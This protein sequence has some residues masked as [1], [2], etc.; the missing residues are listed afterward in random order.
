MLGEAEE[1][2]SY[3]QVPLD[4]PWGFATAGMYR[5]GC[6]RGSTWLPGR[7]PGGGG[8]VAAIPRSWARRWPGLGSFA[9][10]QA[11]LIELLLPGADRGPACRP[12]D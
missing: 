10:H 2:W 4:R 6:L 7:D 5:V 12:G 1:R 9:Y 11:R 3:L 8:G